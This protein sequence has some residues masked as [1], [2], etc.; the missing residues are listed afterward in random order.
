MVKCIVIGGGFAGLSAAAFLSEKNFRVKLLEGSP[1]LGGR[2][3]SL[4]IPQYDDIYDNGQH[5]LMGCYENTLKYLKLIGSENLVEFQKN[6]KVNF[7]ERGGRNFLLSSSSS[8]YPINLFFAILKYNAIRFRDRLK[9]LKFFLS[10][11]F[12]KSSKL[13]DLTILEWLKKNGQNSAT[14]KSL[15]EILAIGTLNTS[16][17]KASAAMFAE[18]LKKMFLSGNKSSLI[19][20]PASGLSDMYCKQTVEMLL[21][22]GS[23]V[24]I[25]DSVVELQT[26]GNMI[27]KIKTRKTE[28]DD[29]DFII[30]AVPHYSLLKF[31]SN[32]KLPN[33]KNLDL[34]YSTIIN[35][36]LWLKDNPFSESFYG[37]ISS[38]VHWLFNHNKHITLVTS[39]AN[40][41]SEYSNEELVKLFCEEVEDYFPVFNKDL[42]FDY[43]VIREKR[44]T[45][46]PSIKSM[47]ARE[48]L[49]NSYKNLIIAGDWTNT[50]LPST[51]E[52][53]VKSGLLAAENVENSLN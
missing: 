14:I 31:I 5:I 32:L 24:H 17:H 47:A 22:D 41:F 15:W 27:T 12:S 8:I 28:Y 26:D 53:A 1:K 30:S 29:F 49:T 39:N 35:V 52:G 46:I 20:L 43:K 42:V 18:V 38:K 11:A 34:E 3:Y 50:G 23:E 45:F 13:K 33:Y 10:I 4:D 48:N 36:H 40:E 9:V 25:S 2:A 51:I 7:V 21:N 19:V 37:L 6:L 44:A 16:I